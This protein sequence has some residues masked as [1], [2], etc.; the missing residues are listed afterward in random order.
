MECPENLPAFFLFTGLD[1]AGNHLIEARPIDTAFV[2]VYYQI[3]LIA[4]IDFWGFDFWFLSSVLTFHGIVEMF[5]CPLSSKFTLISYNYLF[6]FN[7]F[8]FAPTIV[9]W[10]RSLCAVINL[11]IKAVCWHQNIVNIYSNAGA[12]F[13]I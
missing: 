13:S 10:M 6:I 12:N 2:T 8:K 4:L 5:N 1:C 7:I 11:F 9:N 3:L